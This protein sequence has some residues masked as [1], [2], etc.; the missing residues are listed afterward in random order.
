MGIKAASCLSDTLSMHAFLTFVVADVWSLPPEGVL[1]LSGCKQ[2]PP[3]TNEAKK[4]SA[5][6]ILSSHVVYAALECVSRCVWPVPGADTLRTFMNVQ[7]ST[8]TMTR[9]MPVVQS[10]APEG[11]PG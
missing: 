2:Q 11:G 3:A 10:Q 4:A 6:H 5:L 1:S 9:A 8:H 7:G